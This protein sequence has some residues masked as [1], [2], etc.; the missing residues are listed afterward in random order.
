MSGRCGLSAGGP[1][2]QGHVP[3]GTRLCQP[4]P[5]SPLRGRCHSSSS[6][7]L[8][9]RSRCHIALRA[10]ARSLAAR[11]SSSCGESCAAHAS[12]GACRSCS[13]GG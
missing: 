3:V 11:R 7:R 13:A 1:H 10:A 8:S 5:A 9:Q 2:L 12:S 6:A 4:A